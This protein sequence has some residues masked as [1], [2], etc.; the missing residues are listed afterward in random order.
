MRAPGAVQERAARAR[1]QLARHEER[2]RARTLGLEASLA[3]RRAGAA[4]SAAPDPALGVAAGFQFD[5]PRY[6]YI[7]AEV[8]PSL[9]QKILRPRGRRKR[10]A[11]A[12]QAIVVAREPSIELVAEKRVAEALRL[13]DV[14]KRLLEQ[15][16]PKNTARAYEGDWKRFTA[17]C[18]RMGADPLPAEEKTLQ[19]YLAHLADENRP[20]ERA[21]G[22]GGACK[23]TTIS[24]AL[25]AI[26]TIHQTQGHPSP[27]THAVKRDAKQ[28]RKALKLRLRRAAPLLPEHLRKIVALMGDGEIDRRDKAIILLGWACALRRS[29]LAALMRL[30][31]A[32]VGG[33]LVVTIQSSKT[34]QEGAGAQVFAEAAVDPVLCPLAAVRAWLEVFDGERLFCRTRGTMPAYLDR[35]AKLPEREVDELVKKWA[36]RAEL[37]SYGNYVWSA[38]SLRAG[39]V[40]EAAIQGWPEWRI[41]ERSRHESSEVLQGYIRMA[42]PMMRPEEKGLL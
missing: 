32:F 41:K 27:L 22:K 23:P 35:A 11:R 5:G 37:E 3:A 28:V 4:R 29:E 30:D 25:S 6:W 14:R 21:G 31:L 12:P 38:H 10:P 19:L 9:L 24:R 33:R 2:R 36:A 8:K 18:E 26:S 34:D 1:A 20:P 42:Q 39:F 17:W 7:I 15:G 40:T 16:T 13:L